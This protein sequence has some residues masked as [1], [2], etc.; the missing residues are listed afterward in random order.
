MNSPLARSVRG[1]IAE[2]LREARSAS[3]LA[4]GHVVAARAR[5]RT[6]R[7]RA[8]LPTRTNGRIAAARLLTYGTCY[9]SE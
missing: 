2:A 3:A 7:S 4:L 8:D 9:L 6:L 5:R 1:R